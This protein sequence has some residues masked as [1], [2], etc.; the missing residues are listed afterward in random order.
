MERFVSDFI[1]SRALMAANLSVDAIVYYQSKLRW[2]FGN[3]K[4]LRIMFSRELQDM[5]P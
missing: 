2:A 3:P 5:F 1:A 4:Y